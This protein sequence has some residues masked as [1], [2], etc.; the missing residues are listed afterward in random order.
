M[1]AVATAP[2]EQDLPHAE[3]EEMIDRLNEELVALQHDLDAREGVISAAV[4]TGAAF[5]LRDQAALL[6]ALR[7]QVRAVARFER[8][9]AEAA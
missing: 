2:R 5:R 4:L 1:A 6:S 7:L 8:A 9:A 3:L